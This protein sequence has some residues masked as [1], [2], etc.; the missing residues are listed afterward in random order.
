MKKSIIGFG[1]KPNNA[2]ALCLTT[3]RETNLGNAEYRI[4]A[5]P[6]LREFP[7]YME[8][9]V[10]VL[11]PATGL[12]YA[13]EYLPA[14]LVRKPL[15]WGNV[16]ITIEGTRMAVNKA[17]EETFTG[18]RVREEP[19]KEPRPA[20][21]DAFLRRMKEI[22][23]EIESLTDKNPQLRE[24]CAVVFFATKRNNEEKTADGVSL[25]SGKAEVLVDSIVIPGRRSKAIAEM[26]QKAVAK[27]ST[28]QLIR[29]M[30]HADNF[31]LERAAG[32]HRDGAGN[33]PP[34][35]AVRKAY[36]QATFRGKKRS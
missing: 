13:V 22:A 34:L 18:G 31:A 12:T 25:I 10:N 21:V 3:N 9:A 7:R 14:N 16:E 6:Y 5:D 17:P 26:I 8:L 2:K 11:D 28:W 24:E 33:N 4:I 1:Y 30:D 23:Q 20:K 36:R 15:E 29:K 32:L 19:P 35:A 27:I